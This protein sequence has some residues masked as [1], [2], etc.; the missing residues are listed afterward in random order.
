MANEI[1]KRDA[2]YITVMTGVTDDASLDISQLRVDPTTKRLKVDQ[3]ALTAG[4][5]IVGLGAGTEYIGKVRITDG[6]NNTTIHDGH[7]P[8]MGY[9]EAIGHGSTNGDITI[10][11]TMGRRTAIG[12]TSY[13]ILQEAD[14]VQPSANTQ[15][16]IESASANDAS[17]GTGIQQVTIEYFSSTWGD[18]K[19][20]T[21]T[22]NG[23]TQVALGVAD[24]YRIHKMYANRVGSGGV[25]AGL[26]KLTD[27]TEATLYGQISATQAFMQRCIFYVGNG[28]QVTCTEGI[29]GSGTIGGIIGR[30]F[31]TEEDASGNT[32]TRARI[33][34]EVADS[35][36]TYPF[37]ISETVSNPNNK[38]KALGI[39]VVGVVANQTAAGTLKGFGET[40]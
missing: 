39:A 36:I 23:T 11:R 2:N 21:V 3:S 6:T 25:A 18:K 1:N 17:A 5:D 22:M 9:H 7:L 40:L 33:V 10:E 29:F 24:I 27:I 20:T 12:T 26:I 14:F 15:M 8:V 35:Q 19:T 32:V 28:K 31:A 4:T 34:F 13:A 38:N 16:Y 37:K 30:L